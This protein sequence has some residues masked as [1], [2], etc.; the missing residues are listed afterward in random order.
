MPD[1]TRH[2]VRLRRLTRCFV[3]TSALIPF[4]V[5]LRPKYLAMEGWTLFMDRDGVVNVQIIDGYVLRPEQ[6]TYTPHF[7]EAMRLI[8]PRFQRIILVTNQQCVGKGLC[9]Q[10]DVDAIHGRLQG[11]LEVQGTPFDR[12]YCCPHLA[13]ASC[14]CRKPNI[15]MFLQALR[16]FPDIDPARSLM[17]GDTLS[18]MQFARN[19]SIH[20]VHVGA[21]RHPEFETVMDIASSHFDS[22]Y[23]FALHLEDIL[24]VL[25]KS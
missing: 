14:A 18:D 19:A 8:R 2:K 17:V 7:L 10:E 3:L 6:F 15:G 13:E 22:L 25:Y 1:G 11:Q 4:F 24:P 16:D 23:D 9:S 12:V 21:V 5:F 20:A